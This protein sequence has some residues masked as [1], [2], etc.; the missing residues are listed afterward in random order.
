MK[1]GFAEVEYT[2]IKGFMPGE[3]DAY[4]AKGRTHLC[5]QTPQRLQAMNKR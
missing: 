3:F 1:A 2:P 4:Y 5:R